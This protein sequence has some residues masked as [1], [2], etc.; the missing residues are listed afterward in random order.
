MPIRVTWDEYE[1]AYLLSACLDVDNGRMTR[2]EAVRKVS[3]HLRNRAISRGID[4]DP[5]FRNEN[6]ISMQFAALHNCYHE[7]P[8]GLTISRLFR[9]I[10]AL[11]KTDRTAFEEILQEE[12]PTLKTSLWKSF[13][14]W[15]SKA[16]GDECAKDTSTVLNMIS[17]FACKNGIIKKAI[18]QVDDVNIIHR[19]RDALKQ[20][21]KLGIQSSK[22]VRAA[23][24]ALGLY[25]NFIKTLSPA[26]TDDVDPN[27][28]ANETDE[29]AREPMPCSTPLA[30]AT[31]QYVDF[32]TNDSYA[33]TKPVS[34][35]YK[36]KNIQCRGWNDLYISLVREIY[37]DFKSVFP[38]GK[39]ISTGNRIDT[40]I[41]DGMIYPKEIAD[42][43]FLECNVSATGIVSKLR[44]FLDICGIE[45][46]SVLIGY[47]KTGKAPEQKERPKKT[48]AMWQPQFTHQVIAILTKY[49]SYGFRTGSPIEL[50]R[51]RNY[52]E[53]EH[54][55]LP[56]DDDDLIKEIYYA[57][58]NLEGKIYVFSSEEIKR[59]TLS[60]EEV[61]CSGSQAFFIEP[62][63]ETNADWLEELHIVSVD[64]FKEL[65]KSVCP[66][67]SFSLN[68][69]M[70][71]NKRTEQEAVVAEIH[72][73]STGKSIILLQEL[74][75]QLPF[76]PSEKIAWNLSASDEF[77]WLDEGRYFRMAEFSIT[78]AERECISQ[79]VAQECENVGFA[80]LMSIPLA[81]V[82]EQ[83]F[84]LTTNALYIAVY[85]SVLKNQYHL[86]GKILTRGTKEIDIDELLR[87]FCR[88]HDRCTVS[89][90]T[91]RAI[92]LTGS[93]NRQH[94]FTALYDTMVRIDA[95]TFVSDSL[96]DFN[97]ERI[98][99]VL[100]QTVGTK[101]IAIRNVSTFVLFPT[102]GQPWNHYLL[103]SYCYR[104]SE[105]YRLSVLSFNEKN[106][107]MIFHKSI[108]QSYDDMLSYAAAQADIELTVECVGEYF[109][110]N[111]YT[112]KRKY[113]RLP[114]IIE[115][116]IILREER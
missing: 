91:E 53:K 34:C 78:A 89:E 38:I 115:K 35:V 100:T 77:V 98:D 21:G 27:R 4:I 10:V 45:H 33:H 82:G 75:E 9:K 88:D 31:I 102:C 52:V 14:E 12:A 106:A 67:Y 56:Q 64:L 29:N 41:A 22:S 24:K 61:F 76:I 15:V 114:M 43:V 105:L 23:S 70:V 17:V 107:G 8:S 50:M 73:V 54:I 65:L 46:C 20:P 96:V 92:A 36:G 51:F 1:V 40:G 62:F 59:L 68:M 13:L 37:H 3:Q 85:L 39:N 97:I 66:Q 103:E 28:A 18:N 42:G 108:N 90:V 60:I 30:E 7:R 32:A 44:A 11:Y 5:V 84:E 80:S 94:V 99:Y 25:C 81:N 109:F 19:L 6:G 58:I 48:Q 113:A 104:F 16:Y 86:N 83:N 116:A 110:A 2:N 26:T 112:A 63:M 49:Y 87:N 57:G 74:E 93:P 71:G 47:K 69:I 72:R 55:N 95:E 111:G 79:Y 101:S